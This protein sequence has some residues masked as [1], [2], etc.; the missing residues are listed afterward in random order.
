MN[1][2]DPFKDCGFWNNEKNE[3]ILCLNVSRTSLSGERPNL[4]ECT[5]R[6]WKLNGKRAQKADLVFAI[7]TGYIIGV[8]RPLVWYPSEE[9]PGRWEFEGEEIYNS[10]YLFMSVSHILKMRQNPVMYVNM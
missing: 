6:Y 10:P 1:W 3:K 9:F 7:C 4:Y 8:F 5:R 2:D